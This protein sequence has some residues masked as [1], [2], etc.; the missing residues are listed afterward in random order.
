MNKPKPKHA[1]CHD[2][3]NSLLSILDLI[4]AHRENLNARGLTDAEIEHFQYKSFPR[5]RIEIAQRIAKKFDDDLT[6]VPGFFRTH[7]QWDLTGYPGIIFPVRAPTGE[8]VALKIRADRPRDPSQKYHLLS[9]NPKQDK[10]TKEINYP[11]GTAAKL[12]V[13][14]PLD[15]PEKLDVLRITEGEIKADVAANLSSIYTI[16][17]PGVAMWQMA[18]DA[19]KEA[20]P[21]RVLLAFD[22]D[23]DKVTNAD[24]NTS[25]AYGGKINGNG[26]NGHTVNGYEI[27]KALASLYCAIKQMGIPVV[28]E[29]WPMEA[30]KGIDDVLNGTNANLIQCLSDDEA[31]AFCN[32]TLSKDLPP[33]WVFVISEKRFINVKSLDQFGFLE[34]LDHTQFNDK[35]A[36]LYKKDA[37]K[38]VLSNS[39][40]SKYDYLTY[41][42]GEP[43]TFPKDGMAWFNIYRPN[44]LEPVKGD[45]TPFMEHMN[46][47]FPYKPERDIVLQWLAYTVQYPENKIR[48]VLLIQGN[49][50]TGKSY[51]GEMMCVILGEYNVHIISNDILHEKYTGCFKR[52][53]L[54]VVPEIMD[55]KKEQRDLMNKLKPI[56]TDSKITIREMY[57]DPYT[58]RN[59]FNL[60]MFTNHD[61][62]IP[63]NQ[64]NRRFCIIA[65][66]AI[67]KEQEYYET[68]FQWTID[69][70]SALLY[71]FLQYDV[72]GFHPNGQPPETKGKQIMVENSKSDLQKWIEQGIEDIIEPFNND[73]IRTIDIEKHAPDSLRKPTSQAIGRMLKQL[74]CEEICRPV[75]N[76]KGQMRLICIRN[77]DKWQDATTKQQIDEYL[78]PPRSI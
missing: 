42:P 40:F 7:N 72:S 20:N 65:S 17:I 71:Y 50:G 29:D 41:E 58:Q 2:V 15:K 49:E 13:H 12:A 21:A 59:L 77:K 33:D 43:V 16:G 37:S 69:N 45:I 74:G 51:L 38:A 3:Y 9:S 73:I 48:W 67:Q 66:P 5:Q 44:I 28:I 53:K 27:G 34:E 35:F 25:P 57:K 75:L 8:I 64:G 24:G 31:K 52:A 36:H 70:A 14:F 26:S 56:I 60:L 63:L 1:K 39:A 55:N 46:F 4:P 61:D 32:E 68:L 19:L 47:L 23:K 10:Q 22:S 76:E 54:I 30:G 78:R 6:G 11:D 18:I 62:A